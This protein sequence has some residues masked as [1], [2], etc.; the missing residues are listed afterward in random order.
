MAR[1][2]GKIIHRAHDPWGSIEVVEDG[3]IRS[4]H[5]GTAARQSAMSLYE[6]DYLL[7]S[8]TRAMVVPLLFTAP[9]RRVLLVGLGG[10][11]LAKFLLHHYPECRIDAVELRAEV[12][13]AARGHFQ[14]PQ[15]ER[16]EI[17]LGDGSA[18]LGECP[19]ERYDLVLIDAY[20][21]AGMDPQLGGVE[22]LH[23]A[24]RALRP[25][26]ALVINTWSE[27]KSLVQ[28]ME[29]VVEQL[30]DRRVLRLPVEEKGNVILIGLEAPIGLR[31]AG[32]L[33]RRAG[34]LDRT[35]KVG[36]QGQLSALRRNNPLL[37]LGQT[38]F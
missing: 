8:Y 3:A 35:L 2:P 9:P 28:R 32:T 38:I 37:R 15:N 1:L 29:G 11:S 4:L 18:Y 22:A 5:F 25:R 21:H 20:D 7:L 36:L 24:R 19:A 34:E 6:P 26:G 33:K 14:L 13:K 10:G 12:V 30:F 16:L 17:V 27:E 23:A 31:A